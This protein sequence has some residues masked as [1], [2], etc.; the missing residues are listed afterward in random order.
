MMGRDG[1]ERRAEEDPVRGEPGP[2]LSFENLGFA[3]GKRKE[4][5]VLNGASGAVEPGSWVS[6]I[7]PNGCGK[8]TLIKLLGGLLKPQTGRIW[9]GGEELTPLSAY[10]LRRSIG[11][12]FQNPENQFIGA[13]VEEDIAFGLEGQ[14]L[15]RCEMRSRVKEYAG[16]LGLTELL[17]K[18][19]GELSGGQ[20]QR[21]AIASVLA[22]QPKVVIFDEASS[23]LDEKARRELLGL[24]KEMRTDGNYTLLSI[25][26]DAEEVLQSDRVLVLD[27]GVI[28]E[29]LRP[30]EL[31]ARPELLTA[32]R[33]ALPFR[34]QM[35]QAL[36]DY[37]IRLSGSLK[38]GSLE[39]IICPLFSKR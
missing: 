7:G 9:I 27:G 18:H 16:R 33:L 24:L 30:E 34:I 14:C 26:H 2:V 4:N 29:D 13:T 6:L 28:R 23:M 8:S 21:V 37:G 35:Q 3:Y 22:M 15:P 39:E 31:F 11:M 38:D 36:A 25:T 12:V 32:C 10:R 20:K 19:P 17:H 5:P 1:Q